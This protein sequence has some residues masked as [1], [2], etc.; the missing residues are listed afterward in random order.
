MFSENI[1]S[2][3]FFGSFF[4][5]AKNEHQYQNAISG[6]PTQEETGKIKFNHSI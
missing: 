6:F 4:G 1:G 2:L 5:Q 3:E